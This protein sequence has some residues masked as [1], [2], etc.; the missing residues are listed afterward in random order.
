MMCLSDSC[1]ADAAWE[2]QKLIYMPCVHCFQICDME[3]ENSC[4]DVKTEIFDGGDERI[5]DRYQVFFSFL[6]EVAIIGKL[7]T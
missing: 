6:K 5:L 3:Q 7:V 4:F 1:T 2:F